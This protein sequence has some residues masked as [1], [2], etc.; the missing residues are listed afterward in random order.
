MLRRGLDALY[1]L[2]GGLAALALF[3][4][5]AVMMAQV[6]LR[7]FSLHFPG[8]DDLTGYLCVAAA[9]L[10]LA[11][12][13]QRGELI[14]V[15]LLVEQLRPGIRRWVELA[16]LT[17]AALLV[18]TILRWTLGEALFSFEIEEVAQG[19][20]P[21]PLW[22]PKL[23]I[24]IGAGILLI[25]IL[26]NWVTALRGLRPAYQAAAEERAARRDFTG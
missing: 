24:P 26:D 2:A 19:T 13:F 21:F 12:T 22:I 14:R 16:A 6:V 4:I 10:A 11:W 3:G 8:A 17:L 20:V 25:A 23:S 18:A 5:F 1:A 15:G 9:F 7:Q